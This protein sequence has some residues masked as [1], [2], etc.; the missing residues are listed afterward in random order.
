MSFDERANLQ[1]RLKQQE[2]TY[3]NICT[4]GSQAQMSLC[5]FLCTLMTL[6]KD[7]SLYI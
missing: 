4:V 7:Y 2:S 3:A 6:D 5:F 1:L